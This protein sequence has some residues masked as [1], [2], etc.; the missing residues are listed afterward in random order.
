MLSKKGIPVSPGIAFGRALVL[1]TEEFQIPR[2]RISP[3]EC[4]AEKLHVE[5]AF[6]RTLAEYEQLR[7][8]VRKH[9]RRNLL[10]AYLQ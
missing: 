6:K 9:P 4:A 3:E 10:G 5:Q 8:S 2:R 1:D 7:D